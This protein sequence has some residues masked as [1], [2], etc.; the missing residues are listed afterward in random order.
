MNGNKI[1]QQILFVIQAVTHLQQCIL[2]SYL[3]HE[4][5]EHNQKECLEFIEACKPFEKFANEIPFKPTAL[6]MATALDVVVK[7]RECIENET[8][9]GNME[10]KMLKY[11]TDV[12]TNSVQ[13]IAIVLDR[14]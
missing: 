9:F 12:I 7:T 3:T 4:K 6:K 14:N 2:L 1:K 11:A 13:G 10:R 5:S 8:V